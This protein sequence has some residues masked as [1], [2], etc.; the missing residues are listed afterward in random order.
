MSLTIRAAAITEIGRVRRINEDRFLCAPELQLFAVADGVGGLPGGARAAQ[1]TVDSLRTHFAPQAPRSIPAITDAIEKTNETVVK[2]GRE[3]SPKI[4]IGST[5]TLGVV[6][7]DQLL[8]GHVGDSC[9]WSL[10]GS[11]VTPL[12]TDQNLA[13][14]LA[15]HFVDHPEAETSHSNLR[16]L[17]QCMGQPTALRADTAIHDLTPGEKILFATDGVTGFLSPEEIAQTFAT[18]LD[19]PQQLASLVDQVNQYGAPDNITAVV[20][21]IT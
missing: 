6:S 10:R 15:E 7:E 14:A 8:I 16:A 12:T 3:I 21:E 4:G 19:L 13:R 17:T 5:L 2:L 1:A 9:C 11:M 20:L 18:D